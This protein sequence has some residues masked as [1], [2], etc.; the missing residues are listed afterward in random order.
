MLAM[1]IVVF[2]QQFGL[3]Y[4]NNRIFHLFNHNHVNVTT[5]LDIFNMF[6]NMD[7]LT[8][9]E[10]SKQIDKLLSL[11]NSNEL[12]AGILSDFDANKN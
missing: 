4:Q 3:T 9:D 7:V 12:L 6:S 8:S 10:F 5:L 11:P 1:T 2:V